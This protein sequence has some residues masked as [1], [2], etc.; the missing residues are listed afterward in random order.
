MRITLFINTCLFLVS[1]RLA[2][3]QWLFYPNLRSLWTSSTSYLNSLNFGD[4]NFVVPVAEVS[5]V[6]D[7]YSPS[8]SVS[9]ELAEASADLLSVDAME[10]YDDFVDD[11]GKLVS[12]RILL[13]IITLLFL[14]R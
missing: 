3:G 2:Y 1:A 12:N 5:V 9:N 10:D 14:S 6:A 13:I 4:D 8:S 7:K 11:Y